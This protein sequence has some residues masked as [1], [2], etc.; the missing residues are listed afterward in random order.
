MELD[1]E[2][3]KYKKLRNF[4]GVMGVI[5]AIQGILMLVLSND[6]SLPI[7]TNFLHFDE[8][9]GA[10]P[11][12]ETIV[13]IPI[14]PAIAIFL[15]ITAFAH[16]SVATYGYKWYVRKVSSGINPAR[17]YEYA[18]TSSLMIV[19]LA[20]LTGIFD[21]AALLTIAAA[22][23][24]MN[25]F[26]LMMELHN[27]TTE[28]TDW[29]SFYF[30]S[31]AGAIPWIIVIMYFVG[32]IS[33]NL[34]TIPTFVYVLIIVLLI[35]WCTFPLNMILQY[36]KVGKWK[37]YLYGERGYIILSLVSKSALAWII[38]GGTLQGS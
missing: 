29:T 12:T 5:H 32:A 13:N 10:T 11:V 18:F 31:F 28:K 33:V 9:T 25:L 22:N 36:K 35:F 27:Q 34:D 4:N 26:G 3:S 23:A 21:I 2:D 16:L 1:Y 15:F 7:Q 17:W 30:G 38:W 24:S 37:D 6:F 8:L 19:I 20:M 14:G